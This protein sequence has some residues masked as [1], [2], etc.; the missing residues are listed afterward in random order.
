[1]MA[2]FSDFIESYIEVF[3]GEFYVFGESF[4]RC[5]DN[6]DLVLTRCE[7]NNLVLNW[8]KCHFMV[9]ERIVLRN[10][11]SNKGLEVDQ[12]KIEVI[13]KLLL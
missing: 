4:K 3:M 12:A 2:I 8:E 13:V 9:K 1:M 6:L 5:L 10:Q 7:E 11:I